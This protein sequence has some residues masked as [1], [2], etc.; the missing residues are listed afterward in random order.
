MKIYRGPRFDPSGDHEVEV[1]EIQPK[2]LE[3]RINSEYVSI[4]FSV[5]KDKA[6]ERQ[7][8]CR[9]GFED[10]DLIAMI[11][12]FLSRL[13]SQNKSLAKEHEELREILAIVEDDLELDTSAAE[14]I[15]AIRL[16]L[17]LDKTQR[18]RS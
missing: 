11:N 16:V 10:A 15:A 8:I 3:K 4:E 2:V 17:K 14:K 7:A 6:A 5:T 13:T 1:A 12:G 9:V 18:S